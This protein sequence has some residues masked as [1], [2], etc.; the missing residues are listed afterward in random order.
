[1]NIHIDVDKYI[2]EVHISDEEI[3]KR[4]AK[5]V[6]IKKKLKSRWLGQYRSLVTNAST[7]AM[8]KTDLY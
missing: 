4:K 6:P 1:M 8:L 3:A 5:F 7:G 2:L